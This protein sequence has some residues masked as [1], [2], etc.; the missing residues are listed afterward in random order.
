[1]IDREVELKHIED[2]KRDPKCFESLYRKYYEQIMKFV[3]KRMENIDDSREVTA[4]VFTKA[5]VNIKNYSDR[6]FPF[7]SWLYR[8]ALNEITQYYRDSK[9]N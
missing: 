9:Y 1:M 3:Y 7:S 2:S 4:R 5:I 8:I 6:G